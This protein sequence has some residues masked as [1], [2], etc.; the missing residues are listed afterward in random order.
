M[1][2]VLLVLALG[3]SAASAQTP[4]KETPPPATRESEFRKAIGAAWEGLAAFCVKWKLK[5]EALLAADEALAADPSNAKAKAAKDAAEKVGTGA[6]DSARKEYAKKLEA[7]RKQ[8]G[9]LWRQIAQDPVVAKDA[10]ARDAAWGRALELDPKG[11]QALHQAELAAAM[12]AQDWKRAGLLLEQEEKALPPDPARAKLVR[13]LQAKASLT[14][15]LL[16]KAS[17]H[18]M[19]YFLSLPPGWTPDKTWPVLVA[20]EGSGSS[21]R[22]QCARFAGYRKDVPVI[23][24]TPCTFSNAGGPREGKHPWYSAEMKKE[25]A[26]K[27]T[28]DFDDPGLMAALAD[29]RREWNAEEKFF[30]AGYSGGGIICW[31]EAFHRPA[32]LRG[33]FPAC[34]NYG[35]GNRNPGEGGRDLP[36]RAFQ[37]EKDGHLEMLTGSWNAAVEDLKT[38]GFTNYT[39]TMLPEV[40]HTAC[41]EPIFR[42]IDAILKK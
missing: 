31:W 41:H 14:E 23:V 35:G 19:R 9:G 34:A 17:T 18:E 20:C 3:A 13:E 2:R 27:N 5:D 30:I 29:V 33:A 1:R 4:P 10:A 42:E 15:P 40:G 11:S 22:D 26:G 7:T 37:G 8:A 24:L 12:K 36:I 32:E 6:L 21:Y 38:A 25:W 39:R 16:L 28:M